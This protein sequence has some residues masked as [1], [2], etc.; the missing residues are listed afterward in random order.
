MMKNQGSWN[1]VHMKSNHKQNFHEAHALQS[2][3]VDAQEAGDTSGTVD[4]AWPMGHTIP[5]NVML[6]HIYIVYI[7][8]YQH[9]SIKL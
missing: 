7:N 8:I 5:C 6:I 2:W 3:S 1:F 9:S 4:P